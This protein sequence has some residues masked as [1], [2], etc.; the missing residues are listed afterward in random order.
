MQI[1]HFNFV[2]DHLLLKFASQARLCYIETEFGIMK[3]TVLFLLLASLFALTG[4]DFLRSLAGRPTSEDI[5][6]M[7]LEIIRMEQAREQLR[8]DSL[9]MVQLRLRDSIARMD[10]LAALDS[11]RQR[12]G[13]ILNPS[14]LGGLFTTRLESRYYIVVGSFRSRRNAEV[15]LNKVADKGYNPALI[16]FRNGFVAVGV[17]PCNTLKAVSDSLKGVKQEKFCPKDVWI[18]VNE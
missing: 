8:L 15:L 10:S 2:S 1:Y 9:R 12:G 7:K 4:C 11:I 14:N 16:S 5:E 18:L 17:C 3:R 6:R 13:T